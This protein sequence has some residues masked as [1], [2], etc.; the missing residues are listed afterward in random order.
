MIPGTWIPVSS[1]VQVDGLKPSAE[2]TILGYVTDGAWA[3]FG[4]FDFADGLVDRVEVQYAAPA[5]NGHIEFRLD[6][7]DGPAISKLDIQQ[8][9]DYNTYRVVQGDCEQLA[10]TH[11]L[12]V[13]FRGGDD[14]CNIKA[15]RFLKPGQKGDPR[16]IDPAQKPAAGD[17]QTEIETIL[18]ANQEAIEK[19]RTAMITLQTPPDAVVKVKQIRHAFEFGTA[20][21]RR[22]FVPND[23]LN[24]AEQT[25]YKEILKANFNSVVHEN[26]MK[27]YSNEK[28]RDVLTFSDAEAMLDWCEQNGLFT[29]GHCVYWG[30]D[31]LVQGWL[32]ELDDASL[33]EEIKERAHDYFR[34]F[35]DRVHEHDM[36]NEMV[37]C[38]YYK[39]R[40]GAD[41]RKQ[42]FD[43]CHELDPQARLYVNDYSI[44]SGGAT[45]KYIEQIKGFLAAG[46]PV[47]GIGVQGH[48]GGHVNGPAVKEKLDQLAQF[49]LPIKVTEFD[50][51]TK[52][53]QA[54]AKA[55]ATLYITAFA[56][57]AVEGV[58]MWGFWE[59]SHWRPNAAL[60]NADWS[61]T[62]AA[63]TYRDLVFKRWWTDYQ[64]QA[65]RVGHCDI[66]V[67]YG[68]HEVT[69]N[70]HTRRIT[71]GKHEKD[72]LL[73]FR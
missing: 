69:V 71:V 11:R 48:F 54:K 18:A 17:T 51:N 6:T 53:Q 22:A 29:R 58:Y 24:E 73:D 68:E 37:H 49:G 42:M 7:P 66:R 4:P 39:N 31:N 43:W 40:L 67:F 5:S 47:G 13:V 30:R 70:G 46:M 21:N 2:G 52:D 61:E 8:T 10:E 63:K 55:L 59:K 34:H 20:I 23:R 1:A 28:E 72:K 44:L 65:N 56:H 41:I 45:G 60:W 33:R 14:L 36:N 3:A 25:K 16:A 62:L 26:A 19:N 64:G 12:F 27:W 32:K 57:P 15:F 50:A 35:K 9:G 38:H